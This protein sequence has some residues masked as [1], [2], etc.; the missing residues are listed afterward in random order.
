[1]VGA[2]GMTILLS[3]IAVLL[4]V[5]FGLAIALSRLYGPGWLRIPA[6]CYI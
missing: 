6:I 1:L 3:V 4:A 5:I 2:A